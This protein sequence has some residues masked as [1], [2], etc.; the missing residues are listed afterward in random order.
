[1]PSMIETIR[2]RLD[3]SLGRMKGIED[4]AVAENRDGLSEPEQATWDEL[5]KQAETYAERLGVLAS[6]EE[7][8]QRAANTLAK[9]TRASTPEHVTTSAHDSYATPGAYALDYMRMQQGDPKARSRL[10]RALSDVTTAETPG[11]VPPQVTGPVVGQ[12][13][14]NRPSINSYAKPPLPAVGMEVQRPH[15]SQHVMVNQQ[16]TEKTQVAS[17]Q[18]KLDLLK[19]DLKTW[20]GA[21]DVSWQ[22]VER[23]SPAAI[24]L[25]FSDF[26]AVYARYT[27]LSA[28]I[29]LAASITQTTAWD[30]T[31]AG[32]LTTLAHAVVTAVT[33]SVDQ[34]FPDTLWLGLKAYQALVGLTS[35]DG[36]PMFPFLGPQN[37]LG[38]A[39]LVGNVGSIGGLNT[40]VD[41]Y[42]DPNTFI[43]GDSTAV[44][45]YENEGA[46]VRLSVVDVG[47][48]GYNIGVAGMW[49]LLN[50]DPG[51]FVKVT[52]TPPAGDEARSSSS[53]SSTK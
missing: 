43:V 12:W 45:F 32:L 23:S 1:M 6:R 40:V 35:D 15:I 8:D 46:P 42:A 5:H 49:A 36:R 50:T 26:V 21:V 18:F 13:M 9:I 4:L 37:A 20:A 3:E 16:A 51:S 7:I 28:V 2:E 41:P 48:L 44:E 14:S 29:S 19:A 25:I 31:A 22:L 47:V 52:F 33:N 27:D 24:D 17:Q 34:Q 38:S 11:L 39:N 10:T 30:G 53:R